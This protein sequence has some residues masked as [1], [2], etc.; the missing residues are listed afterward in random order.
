MKTGF[1]RQKRLRK[2]AD[3]KLSSVANSALGLTPGGASPSPGKGIAY[4][5]IAPTAKGL[6]LL[7][8]LVLLRESATV[9]R[10]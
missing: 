7:Y 5:G 4:K 9:L 8:R 2:N 6:T 3:W 10:G 1:K